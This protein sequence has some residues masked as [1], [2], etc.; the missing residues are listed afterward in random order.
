[1]NEKIWFPE[2]SRP[3]V[4][5]IIGTTKF[6]PKKQWDA[7][8]SKKNC[9]LIIF[10]VADNDHNQ[11]KLITIWCSVMWYVNRYGSMGLGG[12]TGHKTNANMRRLVAGA[13]DA[14][15]WK[16][17]SLNR[18]LEFLFVHYSYYYACLGSMA[19]YGIFRLELNLMNAIRSE[20]GK[21][22]PNRLRRCFNWKLN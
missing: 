19:C 11:M 5:L 18:K 15:E 20:F 4:E 22:C 7:F 13:D 17:S 9:A 1:M 10:W 3:G 6:H 12:H 16:Q 8:F 21:K 14:V 2:K